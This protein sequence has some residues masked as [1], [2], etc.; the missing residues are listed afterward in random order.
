[1]HARLGIYAKWTCRDCTSTQRQ[2]S[3]ACRECCGYTGRRAKVA[4]GVTDAV[5]RP[6]RRV[7]S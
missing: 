3:Y 7:P 6:S 2:G 1:M 4:T 5:G